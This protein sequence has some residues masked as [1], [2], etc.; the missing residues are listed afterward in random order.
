VIEKPTFFSRSKPIIAF[1]GVIILFFLAKRLP[2]IGDALR[3]GEGVLASAGSGIS[4]GLSRFFASENSLTVKLNACLED[5]SALARDAVEFERLK[6]EN[7]ELRA[8]LHYIE[9]VQTSGIAARLIA[10]SLPEDPLRV[11]LDRGSA[12]GVK[13]GSVVVVGQGVVLGTIQRIDEHTSIVTLVTGVESKIPVAIIGKKKTIGIAEG[14]NGAVMNMNFIP[15]DA[16]VARGDVVTTSGLNGNI[17]EGLLLGTVTEVIDLPSAP[18]KSA[19]L[20]P[21]AD[22]LE[23]SN[24]LILPPTAQ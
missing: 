24:V 15:R 21:F 12:D 17:P 6:D 23:W 14:R 22:P 11:V 18:F 2:V 5:T 9:I 7:T 8:E 1:L 3:A 10:R 16:D 13:E 20:E 19:L 4:R